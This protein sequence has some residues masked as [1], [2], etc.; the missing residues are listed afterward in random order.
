MLDDNFVMCLFVDVDEKGFM[1]LVYQ[2]I[3]IECFTFVFKLSYIFQ[4][5]MSFNY[6]V[7]CIEHC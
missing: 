1:L 6:V 2:S 3:S 5:C 7:L 4:T